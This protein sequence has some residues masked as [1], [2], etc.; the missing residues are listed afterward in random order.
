M[1]R[2]ILILA[3]NPKDTSRLRLDEEVREIGNGLQRAQKR[4]EFVLKQQW[5]VRPKDVRRIMLDFEPNVVHFCGHGEGTKGIAF[6][7]ETGNTKLVGADALAGFFELFADKVG[8]VLLNACYSEIQAKAIAQHIDYVIGMSSGIGD[9]AAIEFAIAFYDALGA[10]KSIEFAYKLARNAIQWASIPE[11]LT[12]VLNSR[13]TNSRTANRALDLREE[14][15]PLQERGHWL[16]TLSATVDEIDDQLAEAIVAHLRRLSND[17]SVTIK[18]IESG[19]V[20]I[21]LE[22][23]REGFERI[24]E[25][26]VTG[27]L[28]NIFGIKV[29]EVQW[30]SLDKAIK[31]TLLQ[32]TLAIGLGGTG[33]RIIRQLKQQV[34]ELGDSV[35]EALNVLVVDTEPRT[36]PPGNERLDPSEY[37]YIGGYSISP[38]LDN[39]ERFPEI[40][41]WWPVQESGEK[42]LAHTGAVHAGAGQNRLIGRLSFFRKYAAVNLQLKAKLQIMKSY[43]MKEQLRRHEYEVSGERLAQVY[44]VS[45]LC[46]GTGAGIFLD[47]AFKLR[48][49]LGNN[50][51]I[52]GIFILPSAFLPFMHSRLQQKRIQAIAYASLLELD[53]YM[54]LDHPVDIQFPDD[55]VQGVSGPFNRVILVENRDTRGVF[56]EWEYLLQIVAQA[57]FFD[58]TVSLEETSIR[59]GFFFPAIQA[60]ERNIAII[61]AGDDTFSTRRIKELEGLP[62]IEEYKRSYRE[63]ISLGERLHVYREAELSKEDITVTEDA[64]L[65]VDDAEDQALKEVLLSKPGSEFEDKDFYLLLQL[66]EREFRNLIIRELSKMGRRWWRQRIPP[67]IRTNAQRRK[68]EREKPYPGRV[69]QDLH[70]SNY[71]DFSDYEKII[72]MKINWEEVFKPIFSRQDAISVKMGE[73]RIYRN[74]LAHMRELP[75]QDREVFVANARALLQ[76]IL[77]YNEASAQGNETDGSLEGQEIDQGDVS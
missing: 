45:S 13:Q 41:A 39:L 63:L 37:I 3:A 72:L 54:N 50:A 38:I 69:Q 9:T 55:V 27:Q 18:R 40:Q 65:E 25:L 22:G 15:Y 33:N 20:T 52:T 76:A 47:L 29:S 21:F 70:V 24:E 23:S 68:Q 2:R 77:Q 42:W 46:G 5:A 36:N 17:A 35:D 48:A 75:L 57:I 12:P 44:I 51:H 53:H 62:S 10:G 32:P 71:L 64:E 59:E 6:E 16:I 58:A 19:S 43:I 1:K 56:V 67:D 61:N 11:H 66:L 73:I 60:H 8:C 30:E 74:K 34:R 4:D 28:I 14:P 31:R 7:D 26:F 49:E